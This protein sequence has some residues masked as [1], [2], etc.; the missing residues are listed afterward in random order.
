[1]HEIFL[2]LTEP[3]A[4]AAAAPA[5]AGAVHACTRD[6]RRRSNARRASPRRPAGAHHRQVECAD[7]SRRSIEALYRA[8]RRRRGDRPDR[9]RRLRAAPG[10][11]G[12]LGEHPRALDRRP[13]PRTL[14]RVLVRQRR[15][16][17]MS[18]APAPTGWSATVPARRGGLPGGIARAA[19]ARRCEICNC[20]RRRHP[21]LG[22]ARRTACTARVAGAAHICAQ[23]RCW[24]PTTTAS[25]C[26][27]G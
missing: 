4:R 15:R 18:T 9:A 24:P 6:D 11:S 12:H 20:H 19:G 13:L 21:G 16:A 8:S 26:S 23:N 2:Q 10:R 22:A 14:A 7:R 25:R 5:A 3:D 17:E 27:D 1:M